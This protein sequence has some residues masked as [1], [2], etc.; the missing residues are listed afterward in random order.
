MKSERLSERI[1]VLQGLDGFAVFREGLEEI[2][3]KR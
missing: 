3:R 2:Q 1:S